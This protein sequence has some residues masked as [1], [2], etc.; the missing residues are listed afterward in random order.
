MLNDGQ[1]KLQNLNQLNNLSHS[2]TNS[3][4]LVSETWEEK[5]LFLFR[6]YESLSRQYQ[7]QS[8][9]KQ[10]LVTVIF[11]CSL[12]LLY[13]LDINIFISNRTQ[14]GEMWAEERC[15]CKSF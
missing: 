7:E 5:C 3:N 11:T 10:F 15:Q 4:A 14:C 12:L 2:L 8:R 13:F 1:F 9:L 6:N